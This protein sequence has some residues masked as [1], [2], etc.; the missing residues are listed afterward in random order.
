MTIEVRAQAQPE[1]NAGRPT[2]IVCHDCG[3]AH[4][5]RELAAGEIAYCT[6]C[7][8]T[9]HEHRPPTVDR[10]LALT[11][12][13]IFLFAVANVYPFLGMRMGGTVLE[14]TLM[15][16]SLELYH[17]G[18]WELAMLVAFT[19]IVAPGLQLGGLLYVLLPIRLGFVPRDLAPVFR[20]VDNM[21]PWSMM[22]VFILGILVSTVKLAGIATLLPGPA[23]LAFMLLVFVLAW[24]QSSID[25]DR[26]WS[27]IKVPMTVVKADG[28][29]RLTDCHTCHL[30]IQIPANEDIDA[31]CPRCEAPLH[32]RKP[33]SIQRTWALVIAA[34]IC[35]IPANLLPVMETTSLGTTQGDTI[36]SGAMYLLH[37]GDWPL[38]VV[39]VIASIIVPLAKIGSLIVL[40]VTVQ[41][42][43]TWRPVYRTRLYRMVEI[44][45]KWSMTDI[46]VVTVLV[47]L[48]QM[49]NLAT[50]TAGWGALF[51]GA[52][53]VLTIFAAMS[54]DPR[55]IWDNLEHRER[56]HTHAARG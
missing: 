50:I 9:L 51:F 13:G 42:K 20:L 3:L 56:E 29:T 14:T 34:A 25:S 2:E 31:H 43:S 39:I 23:L 19:S 26:I 47:A 4:H 16:G 38:T 46:Y 53:V 5:R 24:A 12:G 52:V 17:Q 49:G 45:G 36:A 33:H 30:A 21:L 54:F 7:R 15:T 44:V 55:L 48:V 28:Q 18:K 1:R 27:L 41:K 32:R 40:L 11:L 8:A 10:A 37:H 22:D 6:R 35:Y